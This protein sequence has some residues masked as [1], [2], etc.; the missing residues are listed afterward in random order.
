VKVLHVYEVKTA[1]GAKY[2][3]EIAYKDE[4]KLV[5]RLRHRSPEQKLRLFRS[6]I[7]SVKELG[8]QKA[9]ALR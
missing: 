1:D 4:D 5:L 2:R 8:W 3:G 9:Y 6:G 7:I